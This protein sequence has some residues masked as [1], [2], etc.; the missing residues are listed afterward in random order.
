MKDKERAV[1]E[2]IVDEIVNDLSDR[3]GLQNEW[4]QIDCDLQR[5]IKHTWTNIVLKKIR[6]LTTEDHLDGL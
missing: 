5:E 4:E 3:S 1:A 2:S 6:I